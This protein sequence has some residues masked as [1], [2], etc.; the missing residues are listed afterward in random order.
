MKNFHDTAGKRTRGLPACSA[1]PQPAAPPR[2]PYLKKYQENTQLLS[3]TLVC[4]PNRLSILVLVHLN[5]IFLNS[6]LQSLS[7]SLSLFFL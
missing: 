5:F 4:I 3:G 2:A 6:G 7:L 1:V